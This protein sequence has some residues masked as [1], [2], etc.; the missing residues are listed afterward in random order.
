MLLHTRNDSLDLAIWIG[1]PG[2]VRCSSDNRRNGNQA[3]LTLR[4]ITGNRGPFQRR[5]NWNSFGVAGAHA[6]KLPRRKFLHLA[7]GGAATL[8]AVAEFVPGYEAGGFV[9][10]GAPRNTPAAIVEKL[11]KEI[12]GRKA[13]VT[14]ADIP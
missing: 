1:N 7:A 8:P 4:A 13:R 12:N 5:G 14:R 9:G 2:C 11:N 6:M 3:A 10:I